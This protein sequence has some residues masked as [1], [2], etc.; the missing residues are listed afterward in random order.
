MGETK[1]VCYSQEN[2]L[3]VHFLFVFKPGPHDLSNAV[4]EHLSNPTPVLLHLLGSPDMLKAYHI[5]LF[6][7]S[8]NPNIMLIMACSL[9]ANSIH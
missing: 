7:K 6:I 3:Y 5:F 9:L 8:A 4:H 1:S 2:G